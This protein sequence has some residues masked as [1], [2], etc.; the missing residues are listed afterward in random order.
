MRPG[1]LFG[2][3]SVSPFRVALPFPVSSACVMSSGTGLP[4][5]LNF[6]ERRFGLHVLDEPFRSLL[7]WA[8]PPC[9]NHVSPSPVSWIPGNP[10][11]PATVTS[12]IIQRRRQSNEL[13]K[14]VALRDFDTNFVFLI[15]VMQSDHWI[16][17]FF[18][19]IGKKCSM[20]SFL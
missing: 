7:A 19:T 4:P 16:L 3:P 12:T 20:R 9:A 15:S 17:F 18:L 6:L 1:T 10:A 8:L 11:W 13:R 5:C 2:S 14:G